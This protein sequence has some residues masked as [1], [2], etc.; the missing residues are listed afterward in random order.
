MAK[1]LKADEGKNRYDL[2]P[3]DAL[4]EIT[5]VFTFGSF[6]YADR[7]WEKGMQ[8]G[9]V[10]GACMRHLWAWGRGE[11]YDKE[12]GLRHLAHA[13]CC[14]MFL[15]AYDIRGRSKFDDRPLE[16]TN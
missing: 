9:R 8:W 12:S 13:G 15:L 5:Q 4:E 3:A 16:Y 6:K 1:G 10:F 11:Q 14:V 2:L 7:N